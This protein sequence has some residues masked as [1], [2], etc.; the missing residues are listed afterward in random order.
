MADESVI[1]APFAPPIHGLCTTRCGGV[2]SPPFDTFNL[3]MGCGDDSADVAENRS[4]LRRMLPGSPRWL[5]QVHGSR[6]IHLDDWREDVEADAAWTDRP[7]QVACV[8]VADCLPILVSDGRQAACVAAIHAGWRGLA[9]GVIGKSIAALPVDPARLQAWIGPRIG[10]H[11]YR[12]G[13]T[14]RQAFNDYAT[15]FEPVAQHQW[16]A[17]LPKI[18]RRQ[19][20]DASVGRVIDSQLCTVEDGRF[21]SHRRDRRNGRMAACIW[22]RGDPNRDPSC[23][24]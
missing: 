16:L 20:L 13:T 15:A 9:A 6:V 17:D 23:E 2:G 11:H 7:D 22:K 19:L 14:V 12:V 3:A 24:R 18:A 21:F 1:R 4:R 8:V 10:R 5:R